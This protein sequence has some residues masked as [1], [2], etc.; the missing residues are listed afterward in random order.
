MATGLKCMRIVFEGCMRILLCFKG[1]YKALR[2]R[3]L[4]LLGRETLMC[5]AFRPFGAAEKIA[6]TIGPQLSGVA[7]VLK[8]F[9][10]EGL[11]LMSRVGVLL[12]S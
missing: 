9:R 10:V 8:G 7:L 12:S 5:E 1:L 3:I 11:D 2:A 4:R 6:P